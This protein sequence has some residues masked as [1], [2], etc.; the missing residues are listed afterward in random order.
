MPE[1]NETP[2]I[3]FILRTVDTATTTQSPEI[4]VIPSL[5]P[6]PP[7]EPLAII[8]YEA[9]MFFGAVDALTEIDQFSQRI[10]W[11]LR[12]ALTESALLHARNLCSIFQKQG[13]KGEIRYRDVFKEYR[14][15]PDQRRAIDDAVGRLVNAYGGKGGGSP[16]SV[17]NDMVMHPNRRRGKY[18]IYNDVVIKL[19]TPIRE[20]MTALAT[21]TGPRLDR[22]K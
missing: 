7:A 6:A 13:K 10:K 17:I 1:D 15:T 20:I 5:W 18:G 2:T 4:T 21:L 12:N 14:P 8:E 9:A 16:Q 3:T 11:I 19:A 22:S